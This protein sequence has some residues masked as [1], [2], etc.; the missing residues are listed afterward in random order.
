MLSFIDSKYKICIDYSGDNKR[1]S[2]VPTVE[3]PCF[4]RKQTSM[5]YEKVEKDLLP[6][7]FYPELLKFKDMI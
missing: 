1:F 7:A 4:D 6:H 2:D 5:R 3:T